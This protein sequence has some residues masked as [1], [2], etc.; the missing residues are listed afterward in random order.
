M[1]PRTIFQTMNLLNKCEMVS[2]SKL[3]ST[4]MPGPVH[5]LFWRLSQVGILFLKT[6]QVKQPIL[7]GR[8]LFQINDSERL[9]AHE[10]WEF[11]IH[12][13]AS[14]ADMEPSFLLKSHT[15][16]SAC[17][18]RCIPPCASPVMYASQATFQS[19]PIPKSSAVYQYLWQQ[20]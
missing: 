8:A 11:T 9:P 2:S 17:D 5:P 7:R 3:H 10:E 1:I 6:S 18:V 20:C 19:A 15:R 12:S 13:Y 4:Q 16:E 14:F